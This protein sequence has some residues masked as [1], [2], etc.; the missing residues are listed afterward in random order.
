M[1]PLRVMR[2]AWEASRSPHQP[3][4]TKC[5]KVVLGAIFF[6]KI[7]KC[8]FAQ[9]IPVPPADASAVPRGSKTVPREYRGRV[10]GG[11][12]APEAFRRA[13]RMREHPDGIQESFW[14]K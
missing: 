5:G 7:E 1:R 2:S 12:V 13:G 9:M 6:L 8:H 10:S 14:G 4:D 11:R 3:P